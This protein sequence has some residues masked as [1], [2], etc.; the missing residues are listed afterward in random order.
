MKS[1]SREV[2]FVLEYAMLPALL[3]VEWPEGEYP[4]H[5]NSCINWA[6][7]VT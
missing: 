6:V 1:R 3:A 4:E 5:V 2:C 7:K